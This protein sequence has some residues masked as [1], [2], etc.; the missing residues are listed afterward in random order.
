MN[1]GGL[2]PTSSGAPA[3]PPS[4]P[5]S[6]ARRCAFSGLLACVL[7]AAVLLTVWWALLSSASAVPSAAV[8]NPALSPHPE[9]S[10]PH[11]ERPDLLPPRKAVEHWNVPR[12]HGFVPRLDAVA[13]RD[14]GWLAHYRVVYERE[15]ANLA[16]GRPPRVA[17]HR[18]IMMY[19]WGN[20]LRNLMTAMLFALATDRV[21][22]IDHPQHQEQ[23]LE[24]EGFRLYQTEA[25]AKALKQPGVTWY[26]LQTHKELDGEE[27]VRNTN[28]EQAYPH[29]VVV[30]HEGWDI[31]DGIFENPNVR[32]KLIRLFGG[33]SHQV[34]VN[35]RLFSWIFSRPRPELVHDMEALVADIGL[36]VPE[37]VD[38][39]AVYQYRVFVD[40]NKLERYRQV[41]ENVF[42][43]VSKMLHQLNA[44][45]H[46]HIVPQPDRPLRIGFFVTSDAASEYE[47]MR[48]RIKPFGIAVSDP[49]DN[50]LLHTAGMSP[51]KDA[52]IRRLPM[53]H[54]YLTGMADYA[55]CTGTT[56]CYTARSMRI[57][58]LMRSWVIPTSHV[59][60]CGPFQHGKFFSDSYPPPGESYYS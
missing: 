46:Q 58:G 32:E 60:I 50:R 4:E 28:F 31:D 29:N 13:E 24:P 36:R 44:T 48:E 7:A 30:F 27:E 12:P 15:M 37:D 11:S 6:A 39:V 41:R 57:G 26:Q 52:Y 18:G 16:A 19:G 45:V 25:D 33:F 8:P 21:L 40:D 35:E 1:S 10:A 51:Q 22:L 5:R 14:Y 49:S 43:C 3:S 55:L 2:L 23:F 53:L 38:V 47:D 59:D 34:E 54:W 56:F 42:R 9:H 20:R 17:L